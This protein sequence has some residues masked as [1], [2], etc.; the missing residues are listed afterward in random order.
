MN[1]DQDL[2]NISLENDLNK[3]DLNKNDVNM[4]LANC[5]RIFHIIVVI[6]VLLI[7][8]SNVPSFLILHITFSISLLL[9]WY[10]NNNE[11][12]LTYFEAKLRGLDRTQ[13][14]TH[15]FIAPMY[16]ISNTQWSNI[17]YIVT[18][19]LMCISMYYL[20]YSDK[21]SESWKCFN[22]RKHSIPDYDS[23]SLYDKF[24]FMIK[25]FR[26]LVVWTP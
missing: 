4:V 13:S 1:G 15:Q 10:Y 9:H 16:E 23:L 11:C 8:F 24:V 14:F 20:Y 5:V 19:L 6:F 2:E 3:N 25:C 18:I 12:S 17:C 22:N 21:V 26:P 7:P